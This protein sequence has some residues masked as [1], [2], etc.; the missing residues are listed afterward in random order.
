MVMLSPPLYEEREQWEKVVFGN[1]V[2]GKYSTLSLVLIQAANFIGM[3][4][5][6]LWD[7]K[8]SEGISSLTRKYLSF[9]LNIVRSQM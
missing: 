4:P 7:Y 1:V 8:Q 9:T 6:C 2:T 5:L 3:D